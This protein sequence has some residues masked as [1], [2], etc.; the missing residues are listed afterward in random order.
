MKADGGKPAIS[1]SSFAR[2][3]PGAGVRMN[4]DGMLVIPIVWTNRPITPTPAEPGGREIAP[5]LPVRPERILGSGRLKATSG[6]AR[7]LLTR[8]QF[9]FLGLHHDRRHHP[10]VM[11]GSSLS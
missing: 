10:V 9:V 5:V 8:C 7:S 6:L 4:L 11:L 1:A 3:F 2:D